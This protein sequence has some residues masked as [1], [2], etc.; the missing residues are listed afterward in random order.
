MLV[1]VG[2]LVCTVWHALRH[3]RRRDALRRRFR[4]PPIPVEEAIPLM[5]TGDVLLVRGQ[6][7]LASL[8]CLLS[9]SF[10]SHVATVVREPSPD[11][12]RHFDPLPP[13][14]HGLYVVE[15]QPPGPVTLVPLGPWLALYGGDRSEI[16]WRKLVP[17]VDGFVHATGLPTTCA[18]LETELARLRRES[19]CY[20]TM[21][22]AMVA[23]C[24]PTAAA[25]R[26]RPHC[27]NV[28]GTLLLHRWVGEGETAF[29]VPESFASTWGWMD[30]MLRRARAGLLAREQC[31]VA[32]VEEGGAG[33]EDRPQAEPDEHGHAGRVIA[34]PPGEG[35]GTDADDDAA[36][37][38]EV[39]ASDAGQL[40]DDGDRK[41]VEPE[42]EEEGR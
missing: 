30:A 1:Y 17:C 27:A 9:T 16:H 22:E 11:L 37:D 20:P 31:L 10:Y 5:G 34:P 40:E 28:V 42:H 21:L 39:P 8:V 36:L 2:T 23:R 35:Q 19:T 33:D 25:R 3:R 29:L 38:G 18:A 24:L 41:Q 12:R 14:P 13:A 26:W 7:A 32:A 4:P 15:V 6:D